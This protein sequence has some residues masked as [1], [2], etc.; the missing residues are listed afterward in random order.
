MRFKPGRL[1]QSGGR[2][3][4]PPDTSSELCLIRPAS[5]AQQR[6]SVS[7]DDCCRT[8]KPVV[9][10]NLDLADCTTVLQDGDA[11]GRKRRAGAEVDVVVFCLGRP[12]P[13]KVELG[14]VADQPAATMTAGAE[15]IRQ[16]NRLI[17]A[18]TIPGAQGSIEPR[19]HLLSRKTASG[20][21]H[22]QGGPQPLP[23]SSPRSDSSRTPG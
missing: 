14:A 13:S 7:G 23:S 21:T 11:I 1:K 4:R 6:Q 12:V 10:P 2:F 5:R 15:A 18:R 16:R 20:P 19:R 17:Y 22:I 3:G 9:H 8:A